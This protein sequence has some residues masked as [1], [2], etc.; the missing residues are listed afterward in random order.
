[1]VDLATEASEVLQEISKDEIEK[2]RL[3]IE[4]KAELDYQS[5]HVHAKREG[6][7]KGL[8]KAARRALSEGASLEFVQKIT[9]LDTAT[10]EKLR[11]P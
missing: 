9:G 5:K 8:I 4:L 7:K 11:K 2:A 10:I 1:M 6:I 3:L